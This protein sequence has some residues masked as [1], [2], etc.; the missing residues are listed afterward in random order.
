M[1]PSLVS[2]CYCLALIGGFLMYDACAGMGLRQE[3]GKGEGS[4]PSGLPV[5]ALLTS[6]IA[7]NFCKQRHGC[8]VAVI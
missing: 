8:E 5:C 4:D 6:W 1:R 3:V 2:A 7:Q